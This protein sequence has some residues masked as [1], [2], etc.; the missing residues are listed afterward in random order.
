MKSTLTLLALSSSSVL[1]A[2]CCNPCEPCCVPQPRPPVCCECYVPSFNDMQCDWD[3]FAS[4]DFLY[5][6]ADE[7]D[8]SY[9]A[10]TKTGLRATPVA[11]GTGIIT[12]AGASDSPYISA[13]NKVKHLSSK[14]DPGVRVGLGWKM[15][16]GWDLYANWT[17]YTNERK[18]SITVDPFIGFFPALGAKG[19]LNPWM[20][21]AALPY[22]GREIM[23]DSLSAKWNLVFNQID[24][25]LGRRYWLSK[26]FT[27]RPY[28]GLRGAW[29]HTTFKVQAHQDLNQ[30]FAGVDGLPAGTYI[31]DT[32]DRFRNRNWGVGFIGGLQPTFYLTEE[33][34]LYANAEMS[35]L[36]G[37]LNGHVRRDYTGTFTTTAGVGPV[38]LIDYDAGTGDKFSGM[39]PMMDL[40]IG[41]RWETCFCDNRYRFNLDAGWEHHVFF[42]YN[43]RV[44][45]SGGQIFNGSL[46]DPASSNG[47]ADT[48]YQEVDS[49]LGMGGF[50]LRARFDF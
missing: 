13:I 3:L 2:D 34:S 45:L 18:Q 33:F 31:T 10:V 14:W 41:L 47:R 8:L 5:W 24:L 16:G 36:W 6:Y 19:I 7:T 40:G 49:D 28:A 35:L 32:E 21:P 15:D 27:L 38:D 29:T 11:S 26:C 37:Q 44:Q 20:D 17:Y 46:F 1:L 30:H 22:P 42:N 23:F 25:E 48:N 50:V 43:H 39:Q 12:A 4:V 9:A